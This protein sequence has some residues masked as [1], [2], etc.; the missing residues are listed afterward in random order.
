RP[1]VN[2]GSPPF[3]CKVTY[4]F[5]ARGTMPA[6]TMYWYEASLPPVELFQVEK[7]SS[8]GSLFLGIKGTLYSAGAYCARRILVPMASFKGYAPTKPTSPRGM[9]DHGEWIAACKGGPQAMANFATYAGPLTEKV[10]LGNVAMR[11]GKRIQWNSEKLIA[12]DLPAA[13]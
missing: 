13:D 9:G 3:G 2:T 4:R 11:V 1:A 7:P 6:V 8:G 5:P 12:G 10:L